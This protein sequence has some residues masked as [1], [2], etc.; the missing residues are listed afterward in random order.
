MLDFI[1]TILFIGVG[2]GI[3]G[4]TI[5]AVTANILTRIF[6]NGKNRA[7]E[8][9]RQFIRSTSALFTIAVMLLTSI[10]ISTP[11][12]EGVD[13]LE[14]GWM[15]LAMFGTGWFYMAA[16]IL[17]GEAPKIRNR[18]IAFVN[19]IIPLPPDSK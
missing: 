11:H 13:L 5:G 9:D 6:G 19:K 12:L 2:G 3:I 17:L 16:I 7:T 4:Y 18:M 10:G 8:N 15:Y 1:E 14:S